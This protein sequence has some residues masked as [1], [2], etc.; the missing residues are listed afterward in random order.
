[1]VDT[2]LKKRALGPLDWRM[3]IVDKGGRPTPEFQRRWNDQRNN[4]EL[5][6]IIALGEGEPL[7]EP[8]PEDG[9]GYI[10][11]SSEPYTFYVFYEDEWHVVGVSLFTDL[12][13]TPANYTGEADSLVQVNP[14]EDGLIFTPL[15]DFTDDPTAIAS[16]IAVNGVSEKFMRADAAPAVQLATDSLYGLVKPDGTVITVTGGDITVPLA[17]DTVFGVVKVDGT[18]IT[19]TGGVISA[20]GGGGGGTGGM[21]PLTTGEVPIGFIEDA[22]GQTIGVHQDTKSNSRIPYYL[23]LDT[24]ANRPATMN[25]PPH[26]TAIFYSTD[27]T[28]LYVW[29]GTAWDIVT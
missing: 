11:V 5:I 24:F 26:A 13:D 10:D 1:M 14:T 21:L 2:P 16:D 25:T 18:T 9:A 15:I 8:P 22:F 27:T 12:E 29:S 3:A 20:V 19:E 17:T 6:G 23:G 7:L 28:T 4:N